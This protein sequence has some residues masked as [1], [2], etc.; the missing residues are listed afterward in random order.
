MI[1]YIYYA[2][3]LIVFL[4]TCM[5]IQNMKTEMFILKEMSGIII[6]QNNEQLKQM[7]KKWI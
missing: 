3:L 5:T 6:I 2:L 4:Y 1:K 7:N